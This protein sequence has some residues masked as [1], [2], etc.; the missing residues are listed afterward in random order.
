MKKKEVQR[1]TFTQVSKKA[2][3]TALASP[4]ALSM[5]LIESYKG[6]RA[7]DYLMGFDL[8][9]VLWKKMVGSKSA[10]EHLPCISW[11]RL[12]IHVTD[13]A[14]RVTPRGRHMAVQLLIRLGW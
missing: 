6:R 10:G 14:C 5:P 12:C 4:R 3:E 8:S 13:L 7:L 1:I 11:D 9:P 2:V